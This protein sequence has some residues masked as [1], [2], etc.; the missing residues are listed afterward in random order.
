MS[1]RASCYCPAPVSAL[2]YTCI[3]CRGQVEPTQTGW[4]HA[5]PSCGRPTV[6]GSACA[7]R[8]GHVGTCQDAAQL[9]D[10]AERAES[11]RLARTAVA[12]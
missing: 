10:L 8:T 1:R 4:R 5:V 3:G 9:A 12:A 2:D 6:W 7:R 11:A